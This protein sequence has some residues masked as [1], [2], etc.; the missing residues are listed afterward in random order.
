MMDPDGL[1]ERGMPA[2]M[3][4]DRPW[5]S[6][7]EMPGGGPMMPPG[8]AMPPF[9][10]EQYQDDPSGL[11]PGMLSKNKHV[12]N[13][14]RYKTELCRA[15]LEKGFCKYG[16][17]CQVRTDTIEGCFFFYKKTILTRAGR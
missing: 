2:R 14:A 5:A 16:E 3:P 10:Y 6:N 1:Q 15:F 12:K 4:M 7:P 8:G 17:K 11:Y 13:A 9:A